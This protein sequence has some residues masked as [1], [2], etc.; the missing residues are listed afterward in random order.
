MTRSLSRN[1]FLYMTLSRA[2]GIVLGA[3]LLFGLGIHLLLIRP[4]M[5]RVANAQMQQASSE[6]E[7]SILQLARGT[8]TILYTIR[9]VLEHNTL[10][11]SAPDKPDQLWLEQPHQIA[12][13]NSFFLPFIDN[14]SISSIHLARQDGSELLILRDENGQP[15]NRISHPGAK[16]SE[17]F[18]L[19]WDQE[20]SVYTRT[21][22]DADYDT[23]SRPWFQ[24]ATK[25]T[26]SHHT[27]WTQPYIFL[28]T[29][30]PGITVSQRFRANDGQNYI[31]ALDI[32]LKD[33]S[34]Y[35]NQLHISQHGFALLLNEQMR[36]LSRPQ[37][38]LTTIRQHGQPEPKLFDPI[39]DIANDAVTE[40]TQ[41]WVAD[42]KPERTISTLRIRD[43]TEWFY[44]FRPISLGGKTI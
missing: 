32:R 35:T 15:L 12:A 34:L 14:N 7:T 20:L 24:G 23:K 43:G 37:K 3:L 18:Y 6:M 28:A 36:M 42:G 1:S 40:T 4:T 10:S 22:G 25:N 27:H 33:I 30:D 8:E 41:T 39:L 2:F 9:G 16:G 44:Q 38:L 5:E 26:V 11:K 19:R 13:L 17:V 31:I 29:G 21:Q